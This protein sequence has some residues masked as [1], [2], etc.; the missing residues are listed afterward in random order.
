MSE[1]IQSLLSKILKDGRDGFGLPYRQL[2]FFPTCY[3]N[4]LVKHN[5]IS[6]LEYVPLTKN[7]D[8]H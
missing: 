8:K 1:N 6:F 5:F 2:Q 7:I 3:K 4:K